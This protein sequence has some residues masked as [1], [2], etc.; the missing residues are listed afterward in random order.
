MEKR[1]GWTY[2]GP[3]DLMAEGVNTEAHP[4]IQN[5]QRER[6]LRIWDALR[7]TVAA[8]MKSTKADLQF[9]VRTQRRT[10]R[11]KRA[12]EARYTFR[13]MGT[14]WRDGFSRRFHVKAPSLTHATAAFVMSM[15]QVAAPVRT[16]RT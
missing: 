15:E 4:T 5:T 8:S 13:V 16:V 14:N 12:P 3:V 6:V 1:S 9:Q 10:R 2:V 11:G 7:K